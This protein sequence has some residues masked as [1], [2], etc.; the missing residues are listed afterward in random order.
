MRFKRYEDF[1]TDGFHSTRMD[2]N[3][4]SVI[5]HV[6]VNNSVRSRHTDATEANIFLPGG[7]DPTTFAAWRLTFSDHFPI[8]FPLDIETSDDDADFQ[9]S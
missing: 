3:L 9:G 7:G 6:L 8:T 4:L 5:D 1:V 2:A